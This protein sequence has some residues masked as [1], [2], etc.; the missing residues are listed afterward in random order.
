MDRIALIREHVE[1]EHRDVTRL[2]C[3]VCHYVAAGEREAR[4]LTDL[5]GR[6]SEQPAPGH[7]PS[8]GELD[9]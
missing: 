8:S 5:A 2:G 6:P 7:R 3:P 1:D 9:S 4:R